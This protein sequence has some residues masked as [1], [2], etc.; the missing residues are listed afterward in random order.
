MVSDATTTPFG[1]SVLGHPLLAQGK[2]SCPGEDHAS[3]ICYLVITSRRL[4]KFPNAKLLVGIGLW[5]REVL[6]VNAHEKRCSLGL[7]NPQQKPE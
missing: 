3:A 1:F 7:S 4:K 2:S 5:N 6:I